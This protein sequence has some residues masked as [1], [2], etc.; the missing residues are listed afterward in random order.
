M[1]DHGCYFIDKI[2]I[3]SSKASMR[4]INVL[5]VTL[6]L[7]VIFC[8]LYCLE[9]IRLKMGT[10]SNPGPG[11]VPFFLGV[12]VASLSMINLILTF[13]KAAPADPKNEDRS[14]S[15]GVMRKPMLSFLA[16]MVYGLILM[17]LG[18]LVSTFLL[19]FFL[20]KVGGGNTQSWLTA[21]IATIF[22]NALS[23]LIFGVWLGTQFP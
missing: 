12:F 13:L 1:E 17:H 4:K 15:L 6:L 22:T 16:V 11:F 9:A 7:L 23:Y 20:F 3:S 21:L 19:M 5:R 18:Y 2:K 10:I 8:T 14:F